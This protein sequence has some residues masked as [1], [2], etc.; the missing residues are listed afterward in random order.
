MSILACQGQL[1]W[2]AAVHRRYHHK[3]SDT[4]EDIHT[5]IY[6]GK[7]H[8]LLGWILKHDPSKINFKYSVDLGREKWIARTHN[9]YEIIIWVTWIL[10]GSVS[11][12]ALLWMIV[13]PTVIAFYA[14]GCVNAFCHGEN[15]YSN[16]ETKDHSRN[17]P[18]LGYFGWGNGWHNNH[19]YNP[20]SYNF[21]SGVSKKKVEFDP[22]TLF[23]P[24][25][26][27]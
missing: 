24:F 11:L 26:K 22:C 8:A 21:G 4:P 25:I 15:G 10:V 6:Q 1:L 19:H 18:F 14:E 13:I 7:F 23:L 5:P 27:K 12:T 16:Y 9:Y 17:V 20:G 2:W 3:K